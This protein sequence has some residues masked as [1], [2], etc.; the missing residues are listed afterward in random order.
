MSRNFTYRLTCRFCGHDAQ[1]DDI[2]DGDFDAER[3]ECYS[4]S[5]ENRELREKEE[6]CTR[7]S[8]DGRRWACSKKV[9]YS[10]TIDTV[11]EK[12]YSKNTVPEWMDENV[13]AGGRARWDRKLSEHTW[14][15]TLKSG[16]PVNLSTSAPRDNH[17]SENMQRVLRE[18]DVRGPAIMEEKLGRWKSPLNMRNEIGVGRGLV[19]GAISTSPIMCGGG[20]GGGM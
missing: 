14:L 18:I 9:E 17:I 8:G 1:Y 3:G 10:N 2:S 15:E 7:Y 19:K 6:I 4:C 12:R 5:E 16:L 13:Q 11:L 20:G